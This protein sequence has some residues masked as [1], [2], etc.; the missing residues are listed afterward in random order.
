[1]HHP[2]MADIIFINKGDSHS[3][4]GVDRKFILTHTENHTW[5]SL[6]VTSTC[7]H[8]K[9]M[10]TTYL[11]TASRQ[12]AEILVHHGAIRFNNHGMAV[13]INCRLAMTGMVLGLPGMIRMIQGLP[14]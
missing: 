5:L 12:L 8:S 1:M 13:L 2:L 4:T 14:G 9:R 10:V 3:A 7:K 11:T 6:S